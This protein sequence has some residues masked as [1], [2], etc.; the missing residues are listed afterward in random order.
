MKTDSE[1]IKKYNLQDF[2]IN[3]RKFKDYLDYCKKKNLISEKK[4]F[5]DRINKKYTK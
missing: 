1:S 3:T 4:K 2:L 5:N